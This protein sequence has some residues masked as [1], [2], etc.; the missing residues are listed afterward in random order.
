MGQEGKPIKRKVLPEYTLAVHLDCAE[1][2]KCR[3]AEQAEN[4]LVV[5][6]ELDDVDP[7][8]DWINWNELHGDYGR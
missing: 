7:N 1:R 6:G 4:L 3:L 5:N 8:H 2:S